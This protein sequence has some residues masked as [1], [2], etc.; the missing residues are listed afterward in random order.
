MDCKYLIVIIIC[1]LF[2]STNGFAQP[3]G[4]GDPGSGQPVPIAG[5]EYLIGAGVGLG[6]KKWLNRNK[7]K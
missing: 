4:G 3:G 6:I 7:G 5:I 2:L 1:L